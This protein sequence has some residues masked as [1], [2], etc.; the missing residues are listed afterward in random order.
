MLTLSAPDR[1]NDW[2]SSTRAIP[3][4]TVKGTKHSAANSSIDS[5]SGDS[6]ARQGEVLLAGIAIAGA[7]QNR[8]EIEA[9]RSRAE[10]LFA[11]PPLDRSTDPDVMALR[12]RLLVS[13]N[14]RDLASHLIARLESIGFQHPDYEWSIRG[15]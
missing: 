10:A 3:P 11:A 2:M 4:P 9:L 8:E 1:S 6:P 7:T 5:M 12:V 15:R 14:R 13:G